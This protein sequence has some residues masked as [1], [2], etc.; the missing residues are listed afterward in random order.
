MLLSDFAPIV[1]DFDINSN[2]NGGQST[3]TIRNGEPLFV[4]GFSV[5]HNLTSAQVF[6][7]REITV[8]NFIYII[9]LGTFTINWSPFILDRPFVADNGIVI[10]CPNAGADLLRCTIYY[11]P[12]G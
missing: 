6:A 5:D 11:M 7:I 2:T 10:G 12:Q 9:K 1:E 8:S 3:I 4:Y